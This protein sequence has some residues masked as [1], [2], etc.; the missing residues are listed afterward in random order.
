MPIVPVKAMNLLDRILTDADEVVRV[1]FRD[2]DVLMQT[3]Q[4]V[5]YSRLVEGRFPAYQ[6]VIPKGHLQRVPLAAGVLL[7]AIRQAAITTEDIV[8]FRFA[9]KKLTLHAK[10]D[11]PV[12]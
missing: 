1:S 4:A 12:R 2:N 5:I 11:L 10:G 3:T 9:R 6:Q 7:T 8:R